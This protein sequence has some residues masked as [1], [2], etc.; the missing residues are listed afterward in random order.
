MLGTEEYSI[1][2]LASRLGCRDSDNL[3]KALNI[4]DGHIAVVLEEAIYSSKSEILQLK[5]DLAVGFLN[6]VYSVRT[7]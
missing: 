3:W 6:L 5:D 7:G 2:K 1:S 4:D